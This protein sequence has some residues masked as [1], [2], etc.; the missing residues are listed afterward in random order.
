MEKRSIMPRVLV[1]ALTW[2]VL[3]AMA[4][5]GHA[6]LVLYDNFQAPRIDPD[7]WRGQETFAAGDN[8]NAEALRRIQNAQ[9]RLSLTTYGETFA[10]TGLQTGRFG[11][12]VT[13]PAVVTA[14]QAQVTV[15]SA[16]VQTCAENPAAP[17]AR[18]QM[19]GFFFNDGTS[20]RL[21]DATGDIS[22]GIQKV[23]DRALGNRIEAFV[24]RCADFDCFSNPNVAGVTFTTTW[25]VGTPTTLEIIWQP[26]QDRFRFRVLT[27][28]GAQE[29]QTLSYAG[30]VR[31]N[32]VPQALDFKRIVVTNS[33]ENC[34]AGPTRAAMTILVDNVR[35]NAEAVP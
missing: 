1:G 10:D 5:S 24:S 17:R 27:N 20:L 18:A 23:R 22:A 7:K 34:S 25:R 6:Q 31:D 28:T 13:H 4:A 2:G 3:T 8:P 14:L 29:V 12:K 21:G 32:E 9:L 30:L 11:L 35:V 19:T 33:A 26:A 15:Q 16:V